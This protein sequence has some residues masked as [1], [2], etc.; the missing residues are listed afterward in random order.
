VANFLGIVGCLAALFLGCYVG[1]FAFGH[2]P[3]YLT[4]PSS[5]PGFTTVTGTVVTHNSLPFSLLFGSH[6]GQGRSQFEPL[7]QALG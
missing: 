7:E 4:P 1:G 6:E 5:K 3:H 2:K